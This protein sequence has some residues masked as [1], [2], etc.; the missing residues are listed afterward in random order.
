VKSAPNQKVK[1]KSATTIGAKNLNF[2]QNQITLGHWK[3]QSPP[4]DV[5]SISCTQLS[6]NPFDPSRGGQ[7][8]SRELVFRGLNF[9]GSAID[10]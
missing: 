3:F 9:G 5:A 6:Q 10:R 7:L 4:L 1:L 8:G 2:I